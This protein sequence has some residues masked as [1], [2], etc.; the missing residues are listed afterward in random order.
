MFPGLRTPPIPLPELLRRT[1][2]EVLGDD[3]LGMAAQ[4][5]Y[6]FVLALFPALI[7][8]VAVGSYLPFSV[9]DNLISAIDRI[10]PA[11]IVSLVKGQIESLA[12]GNDGG[13]LTIGVL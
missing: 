7:F 9:L 13:L 2:Q 3:C 5:S 10:A 12:N 8:L 6:F 11:E 1:D 4:L